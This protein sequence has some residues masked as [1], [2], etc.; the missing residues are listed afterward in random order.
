MFS[1]LAAEHIQRPR[2]VGPLVGATGIGRFGSE[3]GG[4]YMTI[5]VRVQE[6]KVVD[7]AYQ[8]YGCP[9]AIACGSLTCELARG[10]AVEQVLRLEPAD[11]VTVLGGLPE[12]KEECAR[13]AVHALR[14]ALH[15]GEGMS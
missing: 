7:A 5:W 8:T 10:R 13:M 4:P 3:G 6:D 12:G 15:S 9:A 2:N 11:I 1:P 14:N